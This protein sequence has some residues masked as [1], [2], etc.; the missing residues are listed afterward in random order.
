MIDTV[1]H[2]TSQ[3]L[4]SRAL[5]DTIHVSGS[6]HGRLSSVAAGQLRWFESGG[7]L[8]LFTIAQAQLFFWFFF[9]FNLYFVVVVVAAAAVV[10]FGPEKY[11]R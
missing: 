8:R 9:F 3:W 10:V 1:R 7:R 2:Y 5:L 6:L 11:I 4:A